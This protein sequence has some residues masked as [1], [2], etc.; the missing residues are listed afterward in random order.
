[1][2]RQVFGFGLVAL[3]AAGALFCFYMAYRISRG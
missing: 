3:L 2:W 1:M